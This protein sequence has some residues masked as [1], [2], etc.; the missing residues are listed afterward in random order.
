VA[1][2]STL[3]LPDRLPVSTGENAASNVVDC[4]GAR[5]K[6]AETPLSENCAPETTTLDTVT[7]EF[8]E[9]VSVTLNAL[10]FPT[11]TFPKLRPEALVVR[12]AVAAIPIPLT[13]TVLGELETSDI[14]EILPDT[15]PAAL[16]E[17]IT[18]N[19]ACFPAAMVI[20]SGIPVI[21]TPAAAALACVTV[22]L[23]P[24]PLVI[25]TD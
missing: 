10:L 15:A 21:V 25:V 4:P 9:F 7:L 18:L 2:L 1:L 13:E 24:P 17:K 20:G 23:D 3:T 12:S 14:T 19:E 8:P 6:P 11:C 22:R 5:I 16:G